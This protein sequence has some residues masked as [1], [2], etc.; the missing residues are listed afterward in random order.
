[1]CVNDQPTMANNDK[2]H[3]VSIDVGGSNM[4]VT[5]GRGNVLH[6]MERINLFDPELTGLAK[7]ATIIECVR[8]FVDQLPRQLEVAA[9]EEQVEF[10]NRNMSI[11]L[12]L[13]RELSRRGIRI[14]PV[15]PKEVSRFFRLETGSSAKKTDAVRLAREMLKNPQR[16]GFRVAKSARQAVE[17]FLLKKKENHAVDLNR[18]KNKRKR[19][20]DDRADS[21]LQWLYYHHKKRR[22]QQYDDDVIV[23]D[24]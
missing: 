5:L 2:E 22:R 24:H 10:S 23:I 6:G 11:E 14:F 19:K 8:W 7:K 18:K 20:D 15:H 9:I 4:G 21:L 16:H 12:K 1:M 3:V 17:Q 13:Y